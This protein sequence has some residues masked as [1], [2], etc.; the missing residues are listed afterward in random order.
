LDLQTA[1]DP[2]DPDAVFTSQ[3]PTQSADKAAA[4]GTPVDRNTVKAWYREIGLGLRQIRKDI[5]GGRSEDRQEQF[6][7]IG[8]LTAQYENDGNPVFSI[9][10]KAKEFLGRL[11]RKGR[12]YGTAALQ[13]FDHDFPSWADGKLIPHGI[14]DI[15][16]NVGHINIG[17]SHETSEFAADSLHWYWN[18]IGKQCYHDAT[19]ILLLC[20]CGGSNAANRYLFKYYLQ[21]LSDSI[22][23]PIR[24]AHLPSYCSKYNPIERRFFSHVGRACSGRLFDSL[25]T[26]VDLMRQTSTRTG[27]R[28]TV[29]VIR[30]AY[31]TGQKIS[32]EMKSQ[33]RI[34]HDQAIPKW[35]YTTVL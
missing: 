13:A 5:A 7:R 21:Q 14:Y 23:V 20:D 32:D 27:L 18:R 24:V 9:D 35:N 6:E 1:G 3:T 10:T 26:V 29:N 33:L 17:L 8:E 2:D 25:E 22:G 34:L 30:C 4:K 16:R 11:Y 19:S 15:R 31:Q 12:T 28:A